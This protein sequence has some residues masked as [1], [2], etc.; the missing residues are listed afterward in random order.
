MTGP[1]F[2][3]IPFLHKRALLGG[4]SIYPWRFWVSVLADNGIA[5]KAVNPTKNNDFLMF[6]IEFPVFPYLTVK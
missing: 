6:M 3:L 1:Q 4:L 2:L 5:Y